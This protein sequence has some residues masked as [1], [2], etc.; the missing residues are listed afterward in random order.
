MTCH[1]PLLYCSDA[2]TSDSG[3]G[4]AKLQFDMV[5]SIA[6]MSRALCARVYSK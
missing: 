3:R 2:W 4:P 1:M 5:R 6:L